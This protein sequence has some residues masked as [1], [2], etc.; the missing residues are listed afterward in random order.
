MKFWFLTL[1]WN[2]VRQ[3]AMFE[4]YFKEEEEE[5]DKEEEEE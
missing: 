1:T 5:V 4:D 3:L 2:Q